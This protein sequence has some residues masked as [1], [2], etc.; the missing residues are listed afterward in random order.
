[1]ITQPDITSA[2]KPSSIFLTN[3][4]IQPLHRNAQRRSRPAAKLGSQTPATQAQAMAAK[5][6]RLS[7]WINLGS[8]YSFL[9]AGHPWRSIIRRRVIYRRV[10]WRFYHRIHVPTGHSALK[11]FTQYFAE[12]AADPAGMP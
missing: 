12:Q 6:K 4:E 2:T 3:R 1:M 5:A 8:R 7:Q 11:W 10:F 9:I